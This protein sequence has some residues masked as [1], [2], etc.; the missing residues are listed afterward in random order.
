M[1]QLSILETIRVGRMSIPLSDN[2]RAEGS[3]FGVKLSFTA[4]ETIALVTDALNWQYE[5]NPTDNTLRG[6]A[7]YLL[8]LCG[9]FGSEAQYVI[10]G[11]GG[12]SIVPINPAANPIEFEVSPTSYIPNGDSTKVITSYLGYN[13]IF[14]RGGITQSTINTGGSY[15]SWIKTSGLFTCYPPAATGELFQLYPT[16]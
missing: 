9:T 15:F 3:L 1:A 13:L 4:P 8:W 10:S 14:V 5:G 2:Y 6:V 7:N 16:I 12:G 11:T